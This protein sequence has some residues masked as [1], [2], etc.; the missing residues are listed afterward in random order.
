MTEVQSSSKDQG[1]QS[2]QPIGQSKREK[3]QV[4]VQ[5]SERS[6]IMQSEPLISSADRI[7]SRHP[8]SR[9]ENTSGVSKGSHSPI[10]GPNTLER[11][12][13]MSSTIIQEEPVKLHQEHGTCLP[14]KVSKPSDSPRTTRSATSTLSPD[15]PQVDME[16]S[17]TA[18]Q[19]TVSETFK[20]ESGRTYYN[21]DLPSKFLV[22]KVDPKTVGIAPLRGGDEEFIAEMNADNFEKQFIR[23]LDNVLVG[24]NPRELTL[25]DRLYIM[26]WLTIHSYSK[27]VAL[28]YKCSNCYSTVEVPD[29]DLSKLQVIDLPADFKEPYPFKLS[30][31]KTVHLKLFRVSDEEKIFAVEKAGQP[32]WIYKYAL[33]LVDDK[34]KEID[35]LVFLQNLPSA[36]FA[37]IRAFQEEFAHGPRMEVQV[38]CS[39]CGTSEVVPV[40]FRLEYF[41]PYGKALKRYFR[42]AV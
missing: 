8:P 39:K 27:T 14:G 29:L 25:G 26:V 12:K 7:R 9:P 36:D 4:S 21:L 15:S 35:K 3:R 16:R 32:S 17:Q 33:T 28:K 41:F 40:T 34:M 6:P 31:G 42:K 2:N 13:E 24:I 1:P 11:S 10:M 19:P 38:E 18:P 23:V 22:Y 20:S 5:F 37:A 30:D